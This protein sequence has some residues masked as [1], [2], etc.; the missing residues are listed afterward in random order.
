MAIYVTGLGLMIAATVELE[1]IGL[2]VLVM[3]TATFFLIFPA[4]QVVMVR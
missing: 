4:L 1:V 2:V 3:A